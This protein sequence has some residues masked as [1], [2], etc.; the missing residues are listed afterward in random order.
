MA[1]VILMRDA[2]AFV[3]LVKHTDNVPALKILCSD[4]ATQNSTEM[5]K[6]HDLSLLRSTRGELQGRKEFERWI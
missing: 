2:G 1:V 5:K 3:V 6:T 4:L